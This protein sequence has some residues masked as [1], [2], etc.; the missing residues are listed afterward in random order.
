MIKAMQTYEVLKGQ[1]NKILK[2]MRKKSM[3]SPR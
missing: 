3:I 1:E 2:K